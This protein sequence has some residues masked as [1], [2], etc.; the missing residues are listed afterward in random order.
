MTAPSRPEMPK[1]YDPRA[2]E[3]RLYARWEASGAFAPQGSPDRPAFTIIMPPPNVTGELHLGHALM[4]TVEDALVRWH[5]MLGDRTLWLPGL[6]HAGIATQ[7]V[8]ERELAREGLTRHDLGREQFVERVW[9]WVDRT[10]RSITDQHRRL[11]ASADW[12]RE[13][14]T[15]DDGPALAVRTTFKRLYDDGLIYRGERIVNWCP[16]CRT[17]ISDLEV[18]YEE[19]TGG[20]WTIRYPL[21]DE[22]G[23]D[24]GDY[25]TMATTRPETILGDSGIAVSPKDERYEAIVGRKA[26]LPIIGRELPIVADNA[27]DPAFGTGAVKVTP[28][29]DIT[30]FEI[31][32]RH[33][34]PVVTV[35]NLDGTM[36][37]QAGPFDGLDRFACRDEIVK[38]LRGAELLVSQEPYT[39]AVGHCEKCGT[40]VEPLVSKQWFVKIKP[41]AVPAI[42]AVESGRIRIVP[43]FFRKTYENWMTNIR[44]WCISRQLWWG[45]RIPV[46]YCDACDQITVEL[47]TP[48]RCGSWGGR[49]RQDEDVRDTWFS[50]GLWPFSTLGW[51]RDTAA[52]RNYYPSD[53]METGYDILFFW[54]ARMIMLGLYDIGDVPFRTVYLHGLVRDPSGQKMSKTKGNVVDPLKL[55]EQYGTDALRFMLATGSSPGLD[56]KVQTDKL[57][58]A[59]N[60]ANKL[61]N[62]ARFVIMKLEH[63]S[64]GLPEEG[65]TQ[66]LSL[67]DR[68]IWSRLNALTENVTDLLGD[69]Q[70][71]EAGRQ[72]YDFLWTEYCDWYIELAKVRLN[73]GDRSP[74]PMLAAVLTQ[75]LKLLHPLMPFV[76]EEIW[77]DL[78]PHLAGPESD[79]LIRA[80]WPRHSAGLNDSLAEREMGVVMEAVRSI[81]NLRAEKGVTADRWAPADLVVEDGSLRSRIEELAGGVSVLAHVRPVRVLD[82]LEDASKESAV[83]LVLTGV[84]IILPLAGLYDLATERTRLEKRLLDTEAELLRLERQLSNEVFRTR[85]PA[86]VVAGLEEKQFAAR[87]RL[88]GIKQNLEDLGRA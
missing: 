73:R 34:L 3:E 88:E 42:E 14:F 59:R 80:A 32:E 30:D 33:N 52:L 76:T 87:S 1:A 29:H 2:V 70:I 85:A 62:A 48:E 71:G 28:A 31:G 61:W 25:I 79:L 27:V 6:D 20:L 22:A 69:F 44:D 9:Q 68:W 40:I 17:A 13:I 16:R 49:R 50:S 21:I 47:E 12:S 8:V 86:Q 11:G 74:L 4:D 37:D 45:H 38:V 19:E 84:R 81:R 39:H 5:R 7:M 66:Y 43:D 64:V 60:F 15:L 46:W 78:R 51:P 75:S 41:L 57:E 77:Q 54:V 55:T 58:N 53:V 36:N 82:S 72:I 65:G 67:D 56:M 63:E 18:D 23:I 10:R 26:R 83:T 24:T 35:M